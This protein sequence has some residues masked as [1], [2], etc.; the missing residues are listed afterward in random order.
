M[1]R[2]LNVATPFTALTVLVP[3]RV[4]L[5]GLVP[6][7]TVIAAEDEV[8]LLPRSSCT[9]TCTAGLNGWPATALMGGCT[10]N[11]SRLPLPT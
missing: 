5:P 7:P 2:P 4:P 10:M 6:I 1:L 11:A 9:S 8:T 3:D